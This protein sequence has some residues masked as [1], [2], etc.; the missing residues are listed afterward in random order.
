MNLLRISLAFVLAVILSLGE[1]LDPNKLTQ[2][3][4]DDW[5]TYNG[6]Y[7]GRRFSPLSKINASNI[8]S[9]SLACTGSTAAETTPEAPSRQLRWL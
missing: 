5:P 6:D 2:P 7:S 4:V 3:P 9:L 1:G 8:N